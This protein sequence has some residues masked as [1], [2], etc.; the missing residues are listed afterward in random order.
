MG[1]RAERR[2]KERHNI[3]PSGA[4]AGGWIGLAVAAAAVIAIAIYA[5]IRGHG[6]SSAAV[7]TLPTMP[8]P[9]K[10]GSRAI[11]FEIDTPA[12]PFVSTSLAGKP[13][14]LEIFATWCP[15]CQRET[16]VLRVIRAKIPPSKLAMLSVSGS[17][18][19]V[20]SS[21]GTNVPETQGDVDAFDKTFGVTW[22]AL[23]DANLT[24][25]RLWGMVG[26]PTIYIVDKNGVIRYWGQGDQDAPTLLKGL[27]K[28]GV[29]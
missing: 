29:R 22:P 8:P 4:G 7:E 12:G 1:S 21:V 16:Q 23:F 18:F 27:A 25:A 10:I 17:P 11:P 9:S 28:A 24:V 15:H 3:Q 13:Y 5:W 14:L 26:F 2:R 20:A 19:G 6:V